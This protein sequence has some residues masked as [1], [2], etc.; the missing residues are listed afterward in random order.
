MGDAVKAIIASRAAARCRRHMRM[1]RPGTAWHRASA[2]VT[3][4]PYR[5]G[6]HLPDVDGRDAR[7]RR[8]RRRARPARPADTTA[9][10]YVAARG[11]HADIG[12]I[13]PGSA[14]AHSTSV[15]QEGVLLDDHLLVADGRFLTDELRAVLVGGRYPARDPDQNIA[16]L[17]A[18]VAACE[19]GIA[20]LRR[21]VA[22][23]GLD[24]VHAYMGHVEANAEASVRRLLRRA[25]PAARSSA[26]PTTDRRC[27]S[28]CRSTATTGSAVIDFTGTSGPHP[29]NFN[30][31]RAVCHAAVLYVLRLLVGEPIP[32]NAGAM[33]PVELIIPE[34][35]MIAPRYPV[36]GGGGQRRDQPADRRRAPRCVRRGRCVAG[37]DEQ[38]VVR[39]R[40]PPVLRDDLRRRGRNGDGRRGER[41]AHTHDELPPHRSRGARVALPGAGRGVLDPARFGWRRCAPGRRRR[42]ATSVVRR[43]DGG[44][45][46]VVTTSRWPP[47]AWPADR[48]AP[49]ASTGSIRADGSIEALGWA[50]CIEPGRSRRGD[51]GRR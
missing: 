23:Y 13:T 36:G 20:E 29:G 18:Q 34:P 49:W 8:R 46:L 48:R 50:W 12:G 35:S 37:N 28:P 11:H 31:P 1:L 7:V 21:V 24:V 30:A 43:G 38:P 22:H 19:K 26:R 16:D 33:A 10:F 47:T 40:P 25:C 2:Y 51:F 5:G 4:A 6:T 17:R 44:Q 39:Q 45:H 9:I 41:R 14:P 15:D 27:R 42:A 32:L 3:N